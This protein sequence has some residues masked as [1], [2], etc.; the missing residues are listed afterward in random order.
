MCTDCLVICDICG[1][2]I[3]AGKTVYNFYLTEERFSGGATDVIEM[4][5]FLMT[6]TECSL[7]H[8][9]HDA[10]DAQVF[11]QLNVARAAT[12]PADN[13]TAIDSWF[14]CYRCANK[15]PDET[16]VFLINHA[17][18][19]WHLSNVETLT[20]TYSL[21]LCPACAAATDL[22]AQMLSAASAVCSRIQ[23]ARMHCISAPSSPPPCI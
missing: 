9:L 20:C 12:P 2:C 6:C 15:V 18:E 17:M 8:R 23:C 3:G 19:Q 11:Q 5:E 4:E 16:S 7:T 21:A 10:L 14:T 1:R 13:I 22:P